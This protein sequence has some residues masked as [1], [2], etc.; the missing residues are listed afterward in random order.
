MGEGDCYEMAPEGSFQP[1]DCVHLG[2]YREEECPADFPHCCRYWDDYVCVDHE[3][4]GW[5]CDD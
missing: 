2:D 1:S 5:R 3:L 4:E